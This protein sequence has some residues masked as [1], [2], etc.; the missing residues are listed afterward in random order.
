MTAK[1][2]AFW[3]AT[4]QVLASNPVN[5]GWRLESKRLVGLSLTMKMVK[6]QSMDVNRVVV[7]IPET[8]HI[9]P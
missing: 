3:H 1:G 4:T 7:I 8:A 5:A 9:F 2:K 6:I